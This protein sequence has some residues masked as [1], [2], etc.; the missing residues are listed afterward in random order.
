MCQDLFL[1]VQMVLEEA[2]QGL[3]LDVFEIDRYYI[4]LTALRALANEGAINMS[5]VEEAMKK[6]NIDPEKPNPI[7]V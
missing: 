1:L 5:K 7:T 2:T 4:V 3:I 6:Y